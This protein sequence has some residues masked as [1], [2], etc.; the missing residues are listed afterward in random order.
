M[1]TLLSSALLLLLLSCTSSENNTEN[2]T[3]CKLSSVKVLTLEY[4]D[5]TFS[6]EV[7]N[8]NFSGK[9]SFEYNNN[10]QIT[11][12]KGGLKSIS[13]ANSFTNWVLYDD[14]EDTVSYPANN[15]IKVE[16]SSNVSP[17]PY[18][19]IFTIENGSLIHQSVKKNYL[20]GPIFFDYDYEYQDNTIIEKHNGITNRTFHLSNGNLQKVETILYSSN[21]SIIGKKEYVF[22]NY[23]EKE[24]L[25]KG[26]FF[27][28]G[29]FF[30]AFSKN[31]YQ[32]IE[33]NS[34]D[35]IN[36]EYILN[37]NLKTL[38]FTLSYDSNNI[39]SIFERVCN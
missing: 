12:V 21:Q 1:K 7:F 19:K 26:K 27:I 23:D 17:K 18:E 24:N 10:N 3:D 14:V 20:S 38:V 5:I 15:Q 22:S 32:K 4:D 35:Y 37:Q 16:H 25:L 30:K 31:N 28:N 9:I 2:N 39:A 8:Q 34:Y 6:N 29:S 33:L 11:K 13:T 36:N